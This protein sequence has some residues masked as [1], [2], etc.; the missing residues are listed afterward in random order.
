MKNQ[1]KIKD[2]LTLR[3]SIEG[4]ALGI[5]IDYNSKEK[6]IEEILQECKILDSLS[7]ALEVISPIRE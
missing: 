1:I 3:E 7:N 4:L 2:E 5:C 6:R